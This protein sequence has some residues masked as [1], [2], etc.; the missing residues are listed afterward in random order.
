MRN[1]ICS[2]S[3][4]I[5]L[6]LFLNYT[7]EVFHLKYCDYEGLF[8]HLIQIYCPFIRQKNIFFTEN[9]QPAIFMR[10]HTV[11]SSIW[12][13]NNSSHAAKSKH[14]NNF[15]PQGQKSILCSLTPSKH[16]FHHK[17]HL[18]SRPFPG[19]PGGV[20]GST[21]LLSKYLYSYTL[22]SVL[23]SARE[24]SRPSWANILRDVCI[25]FH[26]F[27]HPPIGS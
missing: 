15:N 7:N 21:C 25:I 5:Q 26:I 10:K 8:N 17:T 16:T 3:H 20:S 12:E 4:L 22:I 13:G 1:I 14:S 19:F 2:L 27:F 11:F 6:I 24:T 18:D 23:A 9:T